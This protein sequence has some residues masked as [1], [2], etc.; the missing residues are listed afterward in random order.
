MILSIL[1]V[2]KHMEVRF[3]IYMLKLITDFK[4]YLD[5]FTLFFSVASL[6]WEGKILPILL[7][8]L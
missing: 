3:K 1:F 8:L 6:R 5:F 7:E 2:L 4:Q